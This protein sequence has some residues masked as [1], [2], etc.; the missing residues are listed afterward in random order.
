MSDR[1]S[2]FV[3]VLTEQLSERA[4]PVAIDQVARFAMDG[5]PHMAELWAEIAD[6]IAAFDLREQATG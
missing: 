5:D 3:T 4:Y 6:G 2:V 1:T